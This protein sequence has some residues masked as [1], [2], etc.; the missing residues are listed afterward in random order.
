MSQN[1]C[2][3]AEVH[4]T[5]SCRLS[6]LFLSLFLPRF[7]VFFCLLHFSLFVF[8]FLN[9]RSPSSISIPFFPLFILFLLLLL[10]PCFYLPFFSSF[11]SVFFSIFCLSPLLLFPSIHSPPSFLIPRFSL[12]FFFVLSPFSPFLA[13][14]FYLLPFFFSSSPFSS[15][16]L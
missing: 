9:F 4:S 13:P 3:E 16:P 11:S 15:R 5:H 14:A 10:S 8:I 7:L 2:P 12:C 1:L 6:F